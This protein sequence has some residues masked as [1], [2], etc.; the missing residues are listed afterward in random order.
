MSF[1]HS[2]DAMTPS[3]PAPETVLPHSDTDFGTGAA[4]GT[5]AAAACN[6]FASHAASS[7]APRRSSR[8]SS[9]SAKGSHLFRCRHPP[10]VSSYPRPPGVQDTPPN[11]VTS[12]A[13][14]PA[15]PTLLH[16]KSPATQ[17]ADSEI[18]AFTRPVSKVRKRKPESNTN[19]KAHTG[20]NF[21]SGTCSLLR[22]QGSVGLQNNVVQGT[23]AHQ[24]LSAPR[25]HCQRGRSSSEA[26][27][28]RAHHAQIFHGQVP[29]RTV[30]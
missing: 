23:C 15:T 22:R 16:N 3:G 9:G 21:L 14:K 19:P 20:S 29:R 27:A 1:V 30:H 8:L 24:A 10:L 5:T 11:C 6:P 4:F 25:R 18:A 28:H 17:I 26:Y 2:R 7:P 13:F 12:W